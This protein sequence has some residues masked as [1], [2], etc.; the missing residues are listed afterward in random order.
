MRVVILAD[1]EALHLF[2]IFAP[3]DVAAKARSWT[4]TAFVVAARG[5]TDIAEVDAAAFAGG[6]VRANHFI[7]LY[8]HAMRAHEPHD[9]EGSSAASDARACDALTRVTRVPDD[10]AGIMAHYE[11]VGFVLVFTDTQGDC[12]PDACCIH[13]VEERTPVGWKRQRQRVAQA[14]RELA[15][16]A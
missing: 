9:V 6:G 3:E 5:S 14:M 12:A 11:S 16:E 15:G 10:R 8:A 13:T 2:E 1:A 7:Y 4:D